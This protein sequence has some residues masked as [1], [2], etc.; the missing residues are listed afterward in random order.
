MSELIINKENIL[1]NILLKAFGNTLSNLEK[2]TNEQM[3]A[4][5]M[6]SKQFKL[7]NKNIND[8]ISN[9]KITKEKLNSNQKNNINQ[10]KKKK[11]SKK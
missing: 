1:K 2:R 11:F 10:S 7:F 9:V 8:L 6:T 3:D 4:L 5:T